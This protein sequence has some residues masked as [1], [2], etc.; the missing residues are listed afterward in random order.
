MLTSLCGPIAKDVEIN[1][2][3]LHEKLSRKAVRK[4]L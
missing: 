3:A 2:Y 1:Y 4:L